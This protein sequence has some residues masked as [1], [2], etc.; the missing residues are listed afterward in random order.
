MRLLIGR[1]RNVS[2]QKPHYTEDEWALEGSYLKFAQLW[3]DDEGVLTGIEL[4]LQQQK[5]NRGAGL[6]VFVGVM[7]RG[8]TR[9]DCVVVGIQL[10]GFSKDQMLHIIP[11][12][13]TLSNLGRCLL[14]P[15]RPIYIRKGY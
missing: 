5:K 7:D 3:A 8:V 1:R 2:Q 9:D 11:T 4:P 15:T 12:V 6:K 14:L 13:V 10:I